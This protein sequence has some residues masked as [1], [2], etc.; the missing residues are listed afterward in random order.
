ML[1]SCHEHGLTPMLTFH[2]FTSPRW[3]ATGG[4]WESARTADRF[5]RFCERSMRHL[6]DLVPYACTLNEPNL[7]ALLHD[8]LGIPE[9][10]PATQDRIILFQNAHSPAAAE[11]MRAAHRRARSRRSRA[12]ARRRASG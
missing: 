10:P 5:A 6:G 1:D 9:P 8:V 12:C 11:V 7:G 3:I 2:H 4:G